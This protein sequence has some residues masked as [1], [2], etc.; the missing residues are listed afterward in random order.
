MTTKSSKKRDTWGDDD[1]DNVLTQG[2]KFYETRRKRQVPS[3][4]IAGGARETSSVDPYALP[5]PSPVS[6]KPKPRSG[7]RIV[8]ADKTNA[9][10]RTLATLTLKKSKHKKEKEIESDD[11]EDVTEQK[12]A[13]VV[14]PKGMSFLPL[15]EFVKTKTSKNDKRLTSSDSK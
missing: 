8:L 2:K 14:P 13:T 12:I 3:E 15:S 6:I 11:D 9:S 1:D 5:S 10:N 4:G 7:G